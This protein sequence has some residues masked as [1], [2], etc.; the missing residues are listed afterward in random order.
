MVHNL[1]NLCELSVFTERDTRPPSLSL[2]TP[3]HLGVVYGGG[4]DFLQMFCRTTLGKL[5]FCPQ[6]EQ[7]GDFPG[8]GSQKVSLAAS[9]QNTIQRWMPNCSP[10][11]HETVVFL[12]L[13]VV[14]TMP[15]S[16]CPF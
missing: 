1:P 11:M 2:P 12:H 6:S 15:F 13:K 16:E 10:I 9:V 5:G 4:E 8:G 14:L 3:T 7:I